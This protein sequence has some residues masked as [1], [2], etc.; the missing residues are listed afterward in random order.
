[1]VTHFMPY[2][3]NRQS[4]YYRMK[5]KKTHE[6]VISTKWQKN[7]SSAVSVLFGT[8]LRVSHK[9][10]TAIHQK[11]PF[12]DYHKLNFCLQR[13][14]GKKHILIKLVCLEYKTTYFFHS[15]SEMSLHC[16]TYFSM[17]SSSS[18]F[19]LKG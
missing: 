18:M 3:N 1:M 8:S 17:W 12:E 7:H 15:E 11:I 9:T 13:R 10:P 16:E 5:S 4:F 6:A 2:M 19:H 14:C